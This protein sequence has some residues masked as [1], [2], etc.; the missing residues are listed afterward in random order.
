[1]KNSQNQ[2]RVYQRLLLT[3]KSISIDDLS[4]LTGIA[5][6]DLSAIIQELEDRGLVLLEKRQVVPIRWWTEDHMEIFLDIPYVE[7]EVFRVYC[8]ELNQLVH[9]LRDDGFVVLRPYMHETTLEIVLGTVVGFA[10]VEFAKGFLSELG[11]K[12]A[13]FVGEITKAY[14]SKGITEVEIR[15]TVYLQG[16]IRAFIFVKGADVDA[17][18][19]GFSNI[20]Q[21][22]EETHQEVKREKEITLDGSNWKV[23]LKRKHKSG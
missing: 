7:K 10:F 14:R 12:L 13:D 3:K 23:V 11:K 20:V 15:G 2:T 17:V 4:V 5:I 21:S 16:H 8:A 6:T 9:T 22:I 18:K 19:D 1:M